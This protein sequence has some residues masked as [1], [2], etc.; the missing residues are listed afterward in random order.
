M[1][2]IF[3]LLFLTF[4]LSSV[5][6]A[7]FS[8]KGGVNLAKL[9]PKF[10]SPSSFSSGG[11]YRRGMLFGINYKLLLSDLVSLRPGI[12]YSTKGNKRTFGSSDF[13]I[14]LKYLEVPID[15]VYTKGRLSIHT[16]P[17]LAYLMTASISDQNIKDG[18]SPIDMGFNV[19]LAIAFSDFGIGVNYGLGLVNTNIDN[20]TNTFIRNKVIGIYITY[21]Q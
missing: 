20:L 16:G 14:I 19:G 21:V 3:L 1:K 4:I 7:Q 11:E 2:R 8:V 15:F 9:K 13:S 18:M 12:Q 10:V 17:Y 6:F 5:S